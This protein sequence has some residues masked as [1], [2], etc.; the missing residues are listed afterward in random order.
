MTNEIL[1]TVGILGVSWILVVLATGFAPYYNRKSIA[2]GVSVPESEYESPFFKELRRRYLATCLIIGGILAVGSTL[3]NIW[4]SA[5]TTMWIHLATILVYLV[6]TSV[7]YL[8]FYRKVRTYKQNSNWEIKKTAA[9]VLTPDINE[10]KNLNP[11]WFLTYLVVIAGTIAAAFIQYPSLPEQ[12]PMHYNIAGQVDRYAAKSMGKLLLLPLIQFL[13]GLLFFGIYIGISRS[14]RQ[15]SGG[16]LKEGLKKDLAFHRVMR[17]TLFFIG[18]MDL[19]L[20][21]TIEFSML[22]IFSQQITIL[23]PVVF[24]IVIFAMVIYLVIKVGQ[25][26]SRLKGGKSTTSRVAEDDSYWILGVFY[27]NKNDPSFFV[28]KRFGMG[29]TVNFGNPISWI[30]IFALLVLIGL[31]VILPIIIH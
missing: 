4:V 15:S 14:K 21:S 13:I 16:D 26:G 17:N 7:L 25:G 27:F 20:F 6:F 8:M 2:F 12:I 18:L 1:F 19:L 9:A 23:A 31:L 10:K 29:Y 5:K 24:L 28:E 30:A 3:A 22:M 11:L